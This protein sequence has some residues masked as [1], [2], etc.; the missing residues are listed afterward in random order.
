M[1][2]IG[3]RTNTEFVD[4]TDEEESENDALSDD[5][6]RPT[7][8]DVK[9]AVHRPGRVYIELRDITEACTSLEESEQQQPYET[10]NTNQVKKLDDGN[11]G[12]HYDGVEVTEPETSY[13]DDQDA[14]KQG[15]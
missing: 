6:E 5:S 15:T 2:V 11:E 12:V 10:D 8:A 4:M 1:L 14:F 7:H 9:T 3:D 13:R